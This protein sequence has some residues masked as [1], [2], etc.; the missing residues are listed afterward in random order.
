MAR[1]VDLVH[2][3][4]RQNP[5]EEPPKAG[6]SALGDGF[7]W[8]SKCLTR[9]PQLGALSHCFFFGWEGSPTKIDYRKK[10][11]RVPTHSSTP[12]CILP[13]DVRT[14]TCLA[15]DGSSVLSHWKLKNFQQEEISPPS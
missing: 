10:K 7:A 8:L 1:E 4:N 9:S 11:K 5:E 14:S 6:L 15:T 12:W 13:R 2:M 3:G